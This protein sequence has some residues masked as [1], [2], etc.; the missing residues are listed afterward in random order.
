MVRSGTPSS[1]LWWPVGAAGPLPL[2]VQSNGCLIN[3]KGGAYWARAL[4]RRGYVVAAASHL[5][6]TTGARRRALIV[7]AAQ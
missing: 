3:Q 2:I 5:K 7:H 4:V 6:T 1:R